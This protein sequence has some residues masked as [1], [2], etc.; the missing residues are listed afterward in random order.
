MT[1]EEILK[2]YTRE[3]TGWKDEPYLRDRYYWLSG[4][5]ADLQMI[6]ATQERDISKTENIFCSNL[7]K[8]MEFRKMSRQ[9]L[10]ERAKIDLDIISKL[11][12]GEI[13][14]TFGQVQLLATALAVKPEYFFLINAQ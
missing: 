7:R 1:R 8:A 11:T 6:P 9:K 12:D 10:A 5:L 3:Y 14:A 2:H 13:D 4:F